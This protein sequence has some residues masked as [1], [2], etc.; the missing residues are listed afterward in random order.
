MFGTAAVS[1]LFVYLNCVQQLCDEGDQDRGFY[2]KIAFAASM[3]VHVGLVAADLTIAATTATKIRPL[4]FAH[5]AY[6]IL[7][8]VAG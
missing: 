1:L 4:R 3:A 7:A 5:V 2:I 6:G 8:G